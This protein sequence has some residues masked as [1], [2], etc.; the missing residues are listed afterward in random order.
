MLIDGYISGMYSSRVIARIGEGR[1]VR[2]VSFLSF[3]SIFASTIAGINKGLKRIF[4]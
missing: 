4:T 2:S 3:T 1:G